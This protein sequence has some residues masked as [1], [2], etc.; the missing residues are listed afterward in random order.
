[1]PAVILKS[2]PC[3]QRPDILLLLERITTPPFPPAPQSTFRGV[4][5]LRFRAACPPCTPVVFL[6]L[7]YICFELETGAEVVLI[8]IKQS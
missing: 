4:R 3:P 7:D 8:I 2:F 6:L 5:A 1:M